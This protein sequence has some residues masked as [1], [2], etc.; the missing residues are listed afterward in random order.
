MLDVGPGGNN[1]NTDRSWG[2]AKNYRSECLTQSRKAAKI[3]GG[4]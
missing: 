4:D 3:E 1:G 2:S